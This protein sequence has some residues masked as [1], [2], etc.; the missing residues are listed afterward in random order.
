MNI[1]IYIYICI[2]YELYIIYIYNHTIS[3][4]SISLYLPDVWLNMMELNNHHIFYYYI[5]DLCFEI[6][7]WLDQWIWDINMISWMNVNQTRWLPPQI[8][9][10][11]MARVSEDI[12]QNMSWV[13]QTLVDS[14]VIN[15]GLL[16]NPQCWLMMAHAQICMSQH[17]AASAFSSDIYINYSNIF[18]ILLCW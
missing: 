13:S 5:S 14:P 7:A 8:S 1:I 15:Q 6:W 17:E 4:Y 9:W 3:Y 16:P 12:G 10:K 11:L 2:I 18:W